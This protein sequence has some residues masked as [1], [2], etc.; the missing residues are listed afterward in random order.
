MYLG[1]LSCKIDIAGKYTIRGLT[2]L[3]VKKS[4]HSIINTGKLTL[5]LTYFIRNNNIKES[6]K[7]I[8]KIKEGDSI[9]IA[10]GYDGNNKQCFNGYIK[11]IN[12]KQPLELELEDKLYL[13]KKL[14]LKK[15]FKKADVKEVINYLIDECYKK[16]GVRFKIYANMPSLT[17]YNFLINGA[18]GISVLNE[19][20]EKYGLSSFLMNDDETLYCGLTY[21]Y[22]GNTVKYVLNR[23][24]ISVDDLKFTTA[25]D[26]VY[27]VKYVHNMPNGKTKSYEFGDKLGEA[28]QDVH[29]NGNATFEEIKHWANAYMAA[30]KTGGYKGSFTT[31]LVPGINVCDIA[32]IEDPQFDNRK[33]HYYAAT[34][35]TN[36]GVSGGGKLKVE[37]DFK[38]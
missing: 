12:P 16:F 15:S 28:L 36:F 31:F 30:F 8:D 34:V 14:E 5:P 18:N 35:V 32:N 9:N 1:A 20:K 7:L 17:V 23:N 13:F 19:L 27:K 2:E 6:V 37:I 22:K 4:V 3:E 24:T 38:T 25:A 10:I 26:K 11:R 33:G 29:I 21:G